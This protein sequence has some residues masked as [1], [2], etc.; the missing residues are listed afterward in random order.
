MCGIVLIPIAVLSMGGLITTIAS[1]YSTRKLI[2][3]QLQYTNRGLSEEDLAEMD[4]DND[5]E[6][7]KL[8]FI[9]FMLISMDK[10]D[11]QFLE[12]LHEQFRKLD[13]DNSGTLDMDDLKSAVGRSNKN[14]VELERLENNRWNNLSL[15]RTSLSFI[16][17][18]LT[19]GKNSRFSSDS[20]PIV[21]EQNN[22]EVV[23][24]SFVSKVLGHTKP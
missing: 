18:S 5:N 19:G 22:V 6:V 1:W 24:E 13:N 2:K 14:S 3:E 12:R 15:G 10:C 8:E 9:E 16:T 21:E 23:D 7:T 4:Q 11:R 17:T 20:I